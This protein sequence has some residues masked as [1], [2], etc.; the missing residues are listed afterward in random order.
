MLDKIPIPFEDF[1]EKLDTNSKLL[2]S[3]VY[4]SGKT[5]F[6]N[7]FF[8][9]NEGYES[10]PIYPVNYSV[11][12]NKDIFELIKYDVLFQLIG[13][14]PKENSLS[15]NS[16]YISNFYNKFRKQTR[17]PNVFFKFCREIWFWNFE[18]LQSIKVS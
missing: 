4:G 11:A 9:D 3:G 8:T 6:I 14:I 5:T 7:D 2:F 16:L 1:K 12:S 18:S 13:K 17:F 15:I 10:I